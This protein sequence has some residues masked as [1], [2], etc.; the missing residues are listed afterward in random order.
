M[1]KKITYEDWFEGKAIHICCEAYF[2]IDAELNFIRFDWDDVANEDMIKVK[3]MQS[4]IFYNESSRIFFLWKKIFQSN[5]TV[6]NNK[7]KY[8]TNELSDMRTILSIDERLN[9]VHNVK[10]LLNHKGLFFEEES[11]NQIRDYFLDVILLEKNRSFD[12]I[13]SINFKYQNLIKTP[14]EIYAQVCWD[15]YNWLLKFN[16]EYESLD[17]IETSKKEKVKIE[18]NNAN[19]NSLLSIFDNNQ[20]KFEIVKEAMNKLNITK[21]CSERQITA[22]VDVSKMAGTLPGLKNL[23][24]ISTIY[25]FIGKNIPKNLKSRTDGNDY[26]LMHKLA[27]KYYGII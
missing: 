15:F 1:K 3:S 23:E 13:H 24:L 5:L 21:A 27:K 18:I 9:V 11:L 10:P 6:Y 12:F 19:F 14:S 4:E 25:D 16:N 22:F 8:L 2:P 26:K 20:V 7:K 17:L